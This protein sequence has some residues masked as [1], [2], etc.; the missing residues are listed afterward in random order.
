MRFKSNTTARISNNSQPQTDADWDISSVKSV[1]SLLSLRGKYILGDLCI[2][3]SLLVKSTRR[4][5]RT[6]AVR[7]PR[8]GVVSPGPRPQER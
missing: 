5:P 4:V 8:L 2:L 7:V 3:Q 6:R 1:R